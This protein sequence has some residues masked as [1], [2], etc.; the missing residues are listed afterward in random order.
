[1][2]VSVVI[3][4]ANRRP[5]LELCLRSLESQSFAPGEVVVVENGSTDDTGE[6]LS[7]YVGPLELKV[8][9]G[10]GASYAESRNQGIAV[11]KGDWIAFLDDDCEAD[12]SWLERL[13]AAA[14]ANGWEAVG[15]PLLPANELEAPPGYSPDL[16]WAA[17]LSPPGIFGPLAGRRFLPATASLLFK[18]SIV[19]EFPFQ[20]V[21][22][23]FG[24]AS[25]D[26][27]TGREDAQ[28]WRTLRRAGRPVGVERR[29]LAWHHVGQDRLDMDYLKRRIEAD[30]RAHWRRER[31]I[32]EVFDAASD[33]VNAPVAAFRGLFN[34]E[35]R[36]REHARAAW[37]WS[38]RQ[39]AML[40]ASAD[41]PDAPVPTAARSKA[42]TR[43]AARAL[44][45][46]GKAAA[47]TATVH[48]AD[49]LRQVAPLPNRDAP[50]ER[51]VVVLHDFLGD[52]VLAVPMLGQLAAAFPR[53]EFTLITGPVAGPMLRANAPKSFEVEELSP[54]K[55]RTQFRRTVE[56]QQL[57]R[58]AA[59]DAILVV[60][61][62]GLHPAPLF[63]GRTP[64][65]SWTHD[66]GFRQQLWG[67][68]V[69]HPVVKNHDK[70]EAAAILDLLSPF[71]IP[72]KLTRPKLVS[73][74]KAKARIDSILSRAKV[75][76]G[77]LVLHVERD[78]REK[79]WPAKK[80]RQVATHF[81]SR[82]RPV[83]L[84]GSRSGRA[85][86]EEILELDGV[87]SL[88]GLLD[89]GEL[90]ALLERAGA[91]LGSDSGPAHI[92]AAVGV[93]GCVVFGYDSPKR[94][95]PMTDFGDGG[96]SL[97]V[98]RGGPGDW[99][100]EE[101]RGLAGDFA[102]RNLAAADAIDELTEI[103]T[104]ISVSRDD[105]TR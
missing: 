93:P 6:F 102:T 26:Y 71:G 101:R 7:R 64:V 60:Y 57:L 76:D 22:G 59:P 47:R 21:G 48:A 73:A 74:E 50:P 13:T 42:Y 5:L 30:G 86:A 27:E 4:T 58:R 104:G 67:G 17:G 51:M 31:P 62:H 32:D 77:F 3:L 28:W 38:V 41:D 98:L 94:W 81:A 89:S 105:K 29:A 2:N 16:A 75:A 1:M 63:L 82:G 97:R 19:D 78:G 88:H 40:A 68:L 96:P 39:R 83:L 9:T 14:K 15:G 11:A 52:S 18:R 84:I 87:H 72:T 35:G 44:F 54:A 66:N 99:L 23:S 56:L 103:L 45:S 55:G 79:F 49:A 43:A 85:G 20:S 37:A 100:E 8:V 53:T 70:H 91:F 92:A 34:S 69:T 36:G 12:A 95:G 24:G 46:G 25:G 80:F 33:V 90:I 10:T 65:V 61:C